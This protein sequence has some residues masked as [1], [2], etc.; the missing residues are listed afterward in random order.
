MK[1]KKTRILLDTNVW[2]YI[3]DQ[4][5]VSA[6][7]QAARARSVE[8]VVTP[9]LVDELRRISDTT[10][11]RKALQTITHPAWTRLMPEIYDECLELKAEIKRLRPEWVIASPKLTEVNRLR[12]DWIRRTGGFWDRARVDL[13]PR[14]TD[15]S[16]RSDKELDLARKEARE[17]RNRVFQSG[18]QNGAVSLQHV[19]Y[20]LEEPTPGWSGDPVQ[21]WR[22][23]SL[24]FIVKELMVYTSPIREWMDSELDVFAILAQTESTNHLWLHELDPCNVPRQWLRGA[25]EFLQSWHKVTDGTPGDSAISTNLID[26]DFVVSADKNFINFA[27]RCHT[28][29]PFRTAKGIRVAGGAHAIP[30]LLT[31]IL[32]AEK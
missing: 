17:I 29:A 8:I 25:F 18:E 15:E 28:E 4:E 24:F 31:A 10:L 19:A 1:K 13:A 12:Y 5:A 23:S 2:S 9:S 22:A 21:Y 7:A 6:V 26:A 32:D 14:R 30:D 27:N 20:I 16:R 11:R 3:A